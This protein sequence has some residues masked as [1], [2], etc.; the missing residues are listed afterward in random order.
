MPRTEA[1]HYL[2]VPDGEGPWPGIVVIHDI[3]GLSLDIRRACDR[4]AAAGFLTLAPNLIHPGRR[5][6]CVLSMMK[7]LH[8]GTGTPVDEI[9]AAREELAARPDCTGSVGSVGFCIGGG[10]CLLLA[11]QGVFDAAAPNYGNWPPDV[12]ALR[13][14][15]PTVASYGGGDPA[16]KGN[17][18]Q[19]EDILTEGGVPHDVREYPDV[20][21]SFMNDWRDGPLRLRIFEHIPGFRF[22]E[23]ESEDAWR[24]IIAFFDVHLRGS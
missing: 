19:L 9:V 10:F 8:R 22:S 7:S 16:L 2:A 15:C 4:L 14:S 3:G 1:P 11:P 24:R 17:A 18:A 13:A 23:P 5:I 6:R 12:Q 20:G 21:H